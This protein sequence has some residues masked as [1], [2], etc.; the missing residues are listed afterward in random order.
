MTLT[1]ISRDGNRMVW[2]E[3]NGGRH[4][5]GKKQDPHLYKRDLAKEET[6][7]V[8]ELEAEGL[9][10]KNEDLRAIFQN[11]SA[12][13][14]K[15]FFTDATRLTKSSRAPG[16]RDG[17]RPLRVRTRKAEGHRVTDLSVPIRTAEKRQPSRVR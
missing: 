14:S 11:A 15:M 10:P 17:A 6:L 9:R 1:A 4:E 8:D 13:G 3:G 2:Y 7:Q 16:K 5:E 12:D